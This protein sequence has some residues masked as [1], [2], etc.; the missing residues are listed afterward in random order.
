MLQNHPIDTV[1]ADRYRLRVQ[2]F[3]LS[4]RFTGLRADCEN[5][6]TTSTRSG[7]NLF[8]PAVAR[9]QIK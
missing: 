1:I 6:P 8:P 9:H 3:Q 4:V 5:K 7:P 2:L